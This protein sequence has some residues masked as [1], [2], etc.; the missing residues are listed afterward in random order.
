MYAVFPYAVATGVVE[1]PYLLLQSVV[2]SPIA[3]FMIGMLAAP[4]IRYN[5]SCCVLRC[6]TGYEDYTVIHTQR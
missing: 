4:T 6:T 2:F 3:Y 5:T 1:L